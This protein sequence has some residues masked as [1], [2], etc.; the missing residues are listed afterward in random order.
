MRGSPPNL[1]AVLPLVLGLIPLVGCGG[2]GAVGAA[3]MVR[4]SAGIRIVVNG[5]PRWSDADAWRLGASPTVEI[6]GLSDDP[7]HELF[8]AGSALRLDDGRIVIGNSGSHEIRFYDSDG[9]FLSSTGSEGGGPGE[10]ESLAWVQRYGSDSLVAYDS[11]HRRF[12]VLDLD[13]TFVRAA[14]VVPGEGA[15]FPIA[16]GP[17]SD[18]SFLVIGVNV[19]GGAADGVV[20]HDDP[21]YRYSPSGEPVDSLG[22]FPGNEMF[23]Q[24][25]ERGVRIG[26]LLFGKSTNLAVSGDQFYA[27]T[28]DTYEIKRYSQAGELGLVIRKEQPLVGVSQQDFAEAIEV[29]LEG[30][31]DERRRANQA[32]LLQSMPA[33]ATFPAFS[34][35]ATDRAGTLW[36]R[37]FAKP[38]D[39]ERLWSVFDPDGTWL[40]DVELPER[41]DLLDIGFQ[42]VLVRWT[43]DL[44][45]EYVRMYELIKPQ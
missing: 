30:M 3:P 2:E 20:R 9:I 36:V 26:G 43:D 11:R 18:R 1:I 35:I 24:I 16:A 40:C 22:A 28:N 38:G 31:S 23:I 13:G 45:V 19:F 21:A 33:P 10:F 12:S 14:S 39:E 37:E 8:R 5:S 6:G 7:N 34:G 25:S 15:G 29:R 17:F 41:T 42:H 44:D 27:G 4:D 32:G